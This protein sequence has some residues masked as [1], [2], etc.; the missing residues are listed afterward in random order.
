MKQGNL[1]LWFKNSPKT[2]FSTT[3]LLAKSIIVIFSGVVKT[4]DDSYLGKA[5]FEYVFIKKG[6]AFPRFLNIPL[7]KSY[8]KTSSKSKSTSKATLESPVL[9][10]KT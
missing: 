10:P 2:M 7:S 1:L 6:F 8:K 3:S 5:K 9:P 4:I